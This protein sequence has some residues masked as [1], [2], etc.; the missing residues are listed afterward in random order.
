VKGLLERTPA[1]MTFE[2]T[3]TDQGDVGG[4]VNEI[5]DFVRQNGLIWVRETFV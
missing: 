4:F 3:S 2:I 1:Y 5:R